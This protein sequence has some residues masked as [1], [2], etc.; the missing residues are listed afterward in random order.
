MNCVYPF[1]LQRSNIGAPGT[2][3]LATKRIMSCGLW[4]ERIQGEEQAGD[5]RKG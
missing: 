2:C 5:Q 4:K 1:A 3:A